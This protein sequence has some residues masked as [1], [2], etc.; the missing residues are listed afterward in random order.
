M[1]TTKKRFF[2]IALCLVAMVS[3]LG[4]NVLAANTQNDPFTVEC[5]WIVS[6]HTDYRI[7]SNATPIYCVWTSASEGS[8]KVNASVHG[9]ANDYDL[10]DENYTCLNDGTIVDHVVCDIDSEIEYSIHSLAYER[11]K[12]HVCIWMSTGKTETISGYWSP[13]ST[14]TYT[15]AYD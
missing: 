2:A 6:N 14:R 9:K 12:P 13:D 11:G 7:K 1:I 4:I 3:M 8:K 10:F 5:F 15:S